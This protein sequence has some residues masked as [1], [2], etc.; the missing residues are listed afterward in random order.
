MFRKNPGQAVRGLSTTAAR[1]AF[2]LGMG[3]ALCPVALAEPSSTE[4]MFWTCD[5]VATT[6]GL[7]ATPVAACS[8][9]TDQLR[10]EKFGGDFLRMLDWW[11]ENKL[12][13]HARMEAA[14]AVQSAGN[15]RN[16]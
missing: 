4:R 10:D 3:C 14:L 1:F 16:R 11:R 2:T 5:Y 13:A 12:T 9:A 7:D 6:R 15:R 8:A